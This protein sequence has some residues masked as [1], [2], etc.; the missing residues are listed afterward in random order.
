MKATAQ[1]DPL[2]HFYT[3]SISSANQDYF[4][5]SIM[6]VYFGHFCSCSDN[7]TAVDF[8]SLLHFLFNIERLLLDMLSKRQ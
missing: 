2:L 4:Q 6:S 8:N 7:E 5:Q 3:R 1:S